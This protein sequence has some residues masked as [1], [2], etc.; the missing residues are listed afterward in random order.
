MDDEAE[1]S[2]A[3]KEYEIKLKLLTKKYEEELS[4]CNDIRVKNILKNSGFQ[5]YADRMKQKNKVKKDII[6]NLKR[7][8]ERAQ[9]EVSI[10]KNKFQEAE[11]QCNVYYQAWKDTQV[12][13]VQLDAELKLMANSHQSINLSSRSPF[14][15]SVPP[16]PP[17]DIP[18]LDEILRDSGQ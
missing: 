12:K 5:E 17:I 1:I 8:L 4:S 13:K 9:N 7:E 2:S 6:E 10:W 3:I 14:D 11:K 18:S 16:P 15:D